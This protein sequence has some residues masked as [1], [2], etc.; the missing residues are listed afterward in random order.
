[1]T[2]SFTR[3]VKHG[4]LLEISDS[5]TMSDGDLV[6]HSFLISNNYVATVAGLNCAGDSG[7]DIADLS[8][9]AN[10]DDRATAMV[11]ILISDR[12][13]DWAIF[14]AGASAKSDGINLRIA[15]STMSECS[16]LFDSV[17]TRG[18]FAAVASKASQTLID[19][20]GAPRQSDG[21]KSMALILRAFNRSMLEGFVW[22][23][24]VSRIR[25]DLG[26]EGNSTL[27]VHP[28]IIVDDP[29]EFGSADLPD[30]KAEY[31][32]NETPG[33]P[34]GELLRVEYNDAKSMRSRTGLTLKDVCGR[35]Q[36]TTCLGGDSVC[37]Y[38]DYV[39]ARAT[40]RCRSCAM[41]DSVR[42]KFTIDD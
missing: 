16:E 8:G 22:S 19:D 11:P 24:M 30:M 25:R 39:F 23:E 42:S 36:S 4:G 12:S 33:T 29:L 9:I 31:E 27:F 17:D 13:G 37:D 2:L 3:A 6:A 1:M 40:G 32:P 15:R 35:S 10:R 18:N 20:V 38:D 26:T 28:S 14:T 21:I 41:Q 34:F 7:E 5:V